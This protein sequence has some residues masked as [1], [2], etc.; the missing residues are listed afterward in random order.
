MRVPTQEYLE[1]YKTEEERIGR[2]LEQLTEMHLYKDGPTSDI[3][4]FVMNDFADLIALCEIKCRSKG[5]KNFPSTKFNE[6]IIPKRKWTYVEECYQDYPTLKECWVA[7]EWADGL[8]LA[9][10]QK[11]K[12]YEFK[13]KMIKRWDRDNEVLHQL[14]PSKHFKKIR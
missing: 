9:T 5:E 12:K 10:F 4:N 11:E 2:E 14:I 8:F 3:D 7:G 1:K 6:W 13:E